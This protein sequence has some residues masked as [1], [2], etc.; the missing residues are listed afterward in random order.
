ME[1]NVLVKKCQTCGREF[2]SESDVL[3]HGNRWRICDRG[4]LWFNCDCQSTLMIP[5]GKF[6]WFSPELVLRP[7]AKTVFNTLPALKNL[8]NIPS[9]VMELQQLIQNENV[10]SKQLAG[11]AKREPMIASNILKMANNFKITDRTKKIESLEHA[12]SYV[13]LKA[14]HDIIVTAS[15]QSFTT[16][17]LVFKPEQFWNEALLSGRIAEHLARQFNPKILPDEAYLAGC[18]CNVGKIVM[19]ICFPDIADNIVRDENDP[20]VMRP[21]VNG[22]AKHA[23][24]SHRILGEIGASFWGMPDFVAESSTS[25]HKMPRPGGPGDLTLG[26]IAAFANQLTHWL[27]LEPIKLDKQLL[28]NLARKSGFV[29]ERMLDA[30]V[31]NIF[32]LRE[33]K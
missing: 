20:T 10:T 30:F 26:E 29:T 1:P 16:K 4:F 19:S 13:G 31:E 6:E 15:I 25:H 27:S 28:L 24:P 18:L 22:E 33:V 23:A 3:T 21:W 17:C 12:I 7:E 5:K 11:V 32:F 8:P 14:M 2:K 9:V